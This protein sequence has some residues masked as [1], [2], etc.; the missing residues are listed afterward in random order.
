[1][2]WR[3]NEEVV[4]VVNRLLVIAPR[5]DPDGYLRDIDNPEAQLRVMNVRLLLSTTI[6]DVDNFIEVKKKEW[7]A[8][9]KKDK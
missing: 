4:E 3:D 6:S 1:M 7:E 5:F 2:S 9:H 8:K